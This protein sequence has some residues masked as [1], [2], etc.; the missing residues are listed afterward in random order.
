MQC[1]QNSNIINMSNSWY[2]NGL[3]IHG[4]MVERLCW[5]P[6]AQRLHVSPVTPSLHGHWPVVWLQTVP[7][8]P[9]GWQLHAVLE[10]IKD[11]MV[12]FVIRETI[13]RL[14][15]SSV[16]NCPGWDIVMPR[17]EPFPPMRILTV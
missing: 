2:S 5:Y 3:L 1:K 7:D 12:K 8:E 13:P 16:P 10:D 6:F 11:K 4:A 15:G 17:L 9:T 14:T